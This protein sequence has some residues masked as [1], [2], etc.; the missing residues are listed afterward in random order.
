M[1]IKVLETSSFWPCY[2]V[3]P[4]AA[5]FL[6]ACLW[7]CGVHIL[8]A[9]YA[10]R[11]P[12]RRIPGIFMT[13]FLT[14]CAITAFWLSFSMMF[15]RFHAVVIKP[16]HIELVYC[17]PRPNLSL[18]AAKLQSA[19]VHQYRDKGCRLEIFAGEAHF[20]SV[21]SNEVEVAKQIEEAIDTITKK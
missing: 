1:D 19:S 3:L 10:P 20:R 17:W 16:D 7:A 13:A 21:D 9:F 5:L 4:V 14:F 8:A 18:T 12:Y 2:I 15:V 11:V 6:I